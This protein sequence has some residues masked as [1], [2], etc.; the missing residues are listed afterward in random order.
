MLL[1]VGVLQRHL[2]EEQRVVVDN[3]RLTVPRVVGVQA[4]TDYF[5]QNISHEVVNGD[6]AKLIRVLVPIKGIFECN[7]V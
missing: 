5:Q 7:L 3:A 2:T 6:L 4:G 1:A